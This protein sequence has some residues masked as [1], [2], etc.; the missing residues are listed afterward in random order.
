MGVPSWCRVVIAGL[1][2]IERTWGKR[3]TWPR[4]GSI[5]AGVGV[6][7]WCRLD[8]TGKLNPV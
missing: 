1:K 3:Y 2:L 4:C 7:S 6:P 8:D 5:A